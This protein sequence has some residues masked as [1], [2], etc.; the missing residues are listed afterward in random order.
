MIKEGAVKMRSRPANSE[1]LRAIEDA[2]SRTRQEKQGTCEEWRQPDE[3]RG[4]YY[5]PSHR[6]YSGKE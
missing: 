2:L 3:P 4:L 6:K 1:L 5:L